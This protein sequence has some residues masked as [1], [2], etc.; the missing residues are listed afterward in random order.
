MIKIHYVNS[1]IFLKFGVG[2]PC[3]CIRKDVSKCEE[4]N[5]AKVIS[6]YRLYQVSPVLFY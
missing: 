2:R 1:F 6:F 5:R 4:V 3:G